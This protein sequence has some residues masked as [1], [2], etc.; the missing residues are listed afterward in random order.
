MLDAVLPVMYVTAPDPATASEANVCLS[1]WTSLLGL[2]ACWPRL[3]DDGHDGGV[4]LGVDD[5]VGD[6]HDVGIVGRSGAN[7]AERLGPVSD[8]LQVGDDGQG[9]VEAGA[10][11]VNE[12]V[13]RLTFG[14]RECLG[15][16]IRDAKPHRQHRCGENEHERDANDEVRPGSIGDGLGESSG[17]GGPTVGDLAGR[18]L[19][20]G[21]P[22][23]VDVVAGE[24]EEGGHQGDRD[25][26]GDGH[27][28]GGAQAHHREERDAGDEQAG[29]G[30]DHGAT[31]E[32]D[33]AARR[34]GSRAA[35]S[36][37]GRP[38]VW[39]AR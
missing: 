19:D 5:R 11:S 13:V 30:D 20:A 21:D 16:I 29:E 34:R 8:L 31:G 4:T 23:P 2:L 28:G 38:V 17:E 9:T 15:A 39:N 14:R 3:G 22:N 25:E 6:D 7:R 26:H 1:R 24:P 32:D 33:G 10:E 27:R 12:H 37:G 35:A 36:S 18:E